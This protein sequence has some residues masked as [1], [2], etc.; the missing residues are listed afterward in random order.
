MGKSTAIGPLTGRSRL[1]PPSGY[2]G[3]VEK[4]VEAQGEVKAASVMAAATT[5]TSCGDSATATA[6]TSYN[7]NVTG[8]RHKHPLAK[9]LIFACECTTHMEKL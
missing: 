9:N 7:D 2:G 3:A 6:T 5:T 8:R 4:V 1:L